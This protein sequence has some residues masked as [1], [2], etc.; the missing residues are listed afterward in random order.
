[1]KTG[2]WRSSELDPGQEADLV[3]AAQG[4]DQ[5]AF[6]EI[7]RHF[8]RAVYRVAYALTRNAA[9][10]DDVAQETFVRA[11]QALGRFRPGE[12]LRPWLSRI[13]VNQAYSLHRRRKRRPETSIEPLVESG[14]QWAGP[15]DPVERTAETERHERLAEAF[16][17]LSPEHQAVLTLRVVED[18]SY[19][20]IANALGVPAGTVMSRLSRARAELRALVRA[21]GGE[22]S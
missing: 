16:G 1:M 2:P 3:R 15:D 6:A 7:V 20:E 13:A 18:L 9:D 19:E 21:R 10:A 22:E 14:R 12:P 5:A 4:G 17:R 11:Y 8:Q